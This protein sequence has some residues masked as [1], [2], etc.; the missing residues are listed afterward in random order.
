MAT[1]AQRA[2]FR[3]KV[4]DPGEPSPAF[5][6]EEIDVIFATSASE[7]AGQPE[8]TVNTYAVLAGLEALLA[9]A[10][11]LTDYRQ[12]Q[13]EEKRSAIFKSIKELYALWLRKAEKLDA[14]NTA[15]VEWGAIGGG[16]PK[17]RLERPA[18]DPKFR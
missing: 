18:N 6:D 1:E 7:H 3:M 12:N 9:N 14:E 15:S 5:S 16:Q 4:G 2:Y 11:R 13:S 8:Q 17:R 10:A